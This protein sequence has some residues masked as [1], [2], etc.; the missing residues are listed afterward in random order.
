MLSDSL[1]AAVLG[2]VP[3]SEWLA[4]AVRLHRRLFDR[5]RKRIK[6]SAIALTGMRIPAAG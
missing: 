1:S 5:P 4:A 2:A 3:V 6:Q